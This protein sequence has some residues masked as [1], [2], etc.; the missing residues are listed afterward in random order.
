MGTRGRKSANELEIA[1]P[2]PL[3]VVERIK[4]PHDLTDE[5]VEVWVA[6]TASMPAD[7][8]SPANAPLLAQ[9]CRHCVQA[10]RIAELVERATGEKELDPNDYDRLLRMQQRESHTIMHLAVKLRISPSQLINWRG[11]K[12]SGGAGRKP[13]EF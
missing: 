11:N 7:W 5:E 1:G 3:Q 12:K 4:A 9:Y 6:V 8:F 13:W 2:S 10:R